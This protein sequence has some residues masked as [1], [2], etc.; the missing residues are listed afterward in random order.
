MWQKSWTQLFEILK[1]WF[2]TLHVSYIY[3]NPFFNMMQF[4]D[5]FL[6]WEPFR[7]QGSPAISKCM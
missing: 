6:R 5:K 2:P 3:P 1:A 7:L 4:M